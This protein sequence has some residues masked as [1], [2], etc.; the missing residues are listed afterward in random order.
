MNSSAS[1]SLRA[2]AQP[3]SGKNPAMNRHRHVLRDGH[4]ENHAVPPAVF[5]HIGDAVRDGLLR[6]MRF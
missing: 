4:F 6:R 3:R 2:E 1:C 5:R